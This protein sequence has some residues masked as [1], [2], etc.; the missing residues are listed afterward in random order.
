MSTDPAALALGLEHSFEQDVP[1]EFTIQHFDPRLPAVLSTPA[2]IGL[3]EVAA[4]RAVEPSLAPGEITVGTRIEVDHLKACG[5][6]ARL[7]VWARY[8]GASGRFLAFEVTAHCG[9][10][11]IGRGKVFRAIVDP[12]RHGSR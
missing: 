8:E 5:V 4:S 1:H 9:E 10:K 12:T 6:G 11:L 7:R 2:M 3:M